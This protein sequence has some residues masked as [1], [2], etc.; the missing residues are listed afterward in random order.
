MA[1]IEKYRVHWVYRKASNGKL[2][3]YSKQFRYKSHAQKFYDEMVSRAFLGKD[4]RRYIELINASIY[5][6]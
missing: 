2:R 6:G 4:G 1:T 5:T 3:E